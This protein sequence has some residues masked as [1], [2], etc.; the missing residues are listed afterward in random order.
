MKATATAAPAKN[1]IRRA[2]IIL[3]TYGEP[4]HPKFADQYTYSLLILRR[5]TLLVAPIPRPL[6]PLIALRRAI[7]R[8]KTW[9]EEG[10]ASPLE[11][12]THDQRDLLEPLLKE[13]LGE[14][15]H[16]DV[17]VVF[18]FR[19][20]LLPDVMRE[21]AA[22]P[23]DRLIL[24][25][26]YVA[27]SDFTSGV[28]RRDVDSY[29]RQWGKFPAPVDYLSAFSEDDRLVELMAR[30]VMEE[31]EKAGWIG[32]DRPDTALILGAH[33]T[34]I[35]GPP[36]IDTGL[37]PSVSFYERLSARL[38][39]RF[40]AVSVG[41]LNHTMGGEWTSPA[42]EAAAESMRDKGIR[43]VV[44]FPFGFLGDNAESELEGRQIFRNVPE[45]EVLHLPCVN[46]W[47]PFIE[48]LAT[49]IEEQ[50]NSAS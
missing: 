42:L 9:K 14:S 25:P 16:C 12:I 50:L 20:P 43:R 40:A 5:L 24:M 17:R 28:S 26:L 35:E 18:E 8:S 34:V 31:S 37:K 48:F 15:W 21:L 45:L 22:D 1:K 39:P 41:W 2:T 3:L 23:P 29:E 30:F 27:D 49:R 7:T 47:G 32:G 4:Y 11:C 44:Y 10:Y 13:R 36:G 6:L 19:R 46:T 38:A 33:G